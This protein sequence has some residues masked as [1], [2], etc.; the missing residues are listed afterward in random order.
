MS[1]DR[2]LMTVLPRHEALQLRHEHGLEVSGE[3]SLKEMT[4]VLRR[5]KWGVL[6]S[7]GVT[8]ALA[9]VASVAITPKYESTA[10]LEINQDDVD[11]LGLGNAGNGSPSGTNALEFNVNMDTHERALQ[12]DD[13]AMQV[14]VQL[15]L[16]TKPEFSWK[17]SRFDSDQVKA[18]MNAPLENAPHKRER[19]L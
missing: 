19:L 7:I 8:L 6:C 5:R 11:I 18:E 3:I 15:R 16:D 1:G 17:P 13:L 12:T 10:V 2:D 4:G 9:V 14:I